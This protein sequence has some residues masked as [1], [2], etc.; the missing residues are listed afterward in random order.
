MKI[1][2][3]N[4]Y[5]SLREELNEFVVLCKTY[6]YT[7][8]KNEFDDVIR[9]ILLNSG[10]GTSTL[11]ESYEINPFKV[12]TYLYESYGFDEYDNE[13]FL[14][15]SLNEGGSGSI[16]DPEKD[17]DSAVSTVTTGARKAVSGA[18]AVAAGVAVG[19]IAVG[20]YI[21]YLF[22]KSKIKNLVNKEKDAE[23]KKLEGYFKLAELKKKLSSLDPKSAKKIEFPG[24]TEGPAL[25]S[26]KN[27]EDS[28][29]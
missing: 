2:D 10:S 16:Y 9:F 20:A 7:P 13:E 29:K 1:I 11:C 28:S 8:T 21:I 4:E 19:A 18:K 22:K 25:S 27:D 15:E 14:K 3:P 17:F 24:L 23:L 6:N 12:L 5:L 26:N